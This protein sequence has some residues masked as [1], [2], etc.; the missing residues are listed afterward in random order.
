MLIEDGD[1]QFSSN[2][3]DLLH[4]HQIFAV[5]ARQLDGIDRMD[6]AKIKKEDHATYVIAKNPKAF[7]EKYNI[8]S[9]HSTLERVVELLLEGEAA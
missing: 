9:T 4:Q 3:D 5:T 2:K 8:E 1:V 7:C 6:I